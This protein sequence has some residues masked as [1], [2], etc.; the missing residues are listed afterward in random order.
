MGKIIREKIY[1]ACTQLS[2]YDKLLIEL[3]MGKICECDVVKGT[4]ERRRTFGI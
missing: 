2:T 1:R 4:N 3:V